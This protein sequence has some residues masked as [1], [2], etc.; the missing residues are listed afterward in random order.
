MNTF[1]LFPSFSFK[2]LTPPPPPPS[3][4]SNRD[5]EETHHISHPK[6]FLF[7]LFYLGFFFFFFFFFFFVSVFCYSRCSKFR[8]ELNKISRRRLSS[9][10]CSGLQLCGG[11]LG[12]PTALQ[13][14]EIGLNVVVSRVPRSLLAPFPR[15]ALIHFPY[16]SFL[17]VAVVITMSRRRRRRR[18]RRM[19]CEQRSGSHLPPFFFCLI[20]LIFTC[21]DR[22]ATTTTDETRPKKKRKGK[23]PHD[24]ILTAP[25]ILMGRRA[26]VI[27]KCGGG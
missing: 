21:H 10:S 25:S 1:P 27:I 17:M 4:T 7:F 22:G 2:T 6:P 18:R 12:R 20:F 24:N 23:V 26:A 14:A 15:A 5:D 13:V 8:F 19:R 11:S 9:S 3:Y 16:L